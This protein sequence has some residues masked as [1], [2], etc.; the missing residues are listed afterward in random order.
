M[1]ERLIKR[2]GQLRIRWADKINGKDYTRIQK[3]LRPLLKRHQK[4]GVDEQ[5]F[6]IWE[7]K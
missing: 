2:L 5:G 7:E 3:R 1:V 4:I 6:E